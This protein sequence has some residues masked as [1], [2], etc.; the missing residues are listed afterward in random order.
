MITE[1][2]VGQ[3]GMFKWQSDGAPVELGENLSESIWR[4]AS[5]LVCSQLKKKT[6]LATELR[7]L[8]SARTGSKKMSRAKWAKQTC[9]GPKV[10]R[11]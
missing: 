1:L 11:W 6:L 10:D 7:D 3:L 8:L 9:Q 4:A 2:Q 5:T